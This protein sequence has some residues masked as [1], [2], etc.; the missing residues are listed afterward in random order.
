MVIGLWVALG[1]GT[2]QSITK[3]G[4]D[5]AIGIIFWA[6]PFLM[7]LWIAF[8]K[9]SELSLVPFIAKMIRTN[10]LDA[11]KKYQ[12]NYDRVSPF[13]VE[14]AFLKSQ[15]SRQIVQSKTIEVQGWNIDL[16]KRTI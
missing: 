6:I 12:V 7:C 15:E 10:F 14:I 8:F 16:L 1:L 9:V 4:W 5:K 3:S 13:D 2:Y 11:T